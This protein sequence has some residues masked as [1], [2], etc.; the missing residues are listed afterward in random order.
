MN[1]PLK[2]KAIQGAKWTTVESVV[3]TVIQF[4]QVAVLAHILGPKAF[5]L[6]AM[7]TVVVGFG[8]AFSDMGIGNAIIHRQDITNENLSSLYWLNVFAGSAIFMILFLATPII[9]ILYK[10]PQLKSILYWASA[11]FLIV[12]WGQQYQLLLQKEL[13]FAWLAQVEILSVTT[14]AAFA[15]SFALSGYGALSMIWGQLIS[16]SVRTLLLIRPGRSIWRPSRRFAWEDTRGF[17]KF[18]LYQL[19]ERSTNF[20]ST[21]AD[22]MMIG[23]L[24]G[25][26]S[27]GY[28]NVA[29]NLTIQP[30]ARINPILTRVAFPVFSKIQTQ[31][32][33]LK[34]GYLKLVWLLCMIN[35][36]VF[37]GMMVVAANMVATFFGPGWEPSIPLV[38]ALVFVAMLRSTI[39]PIG[40]LLLARGRAD[41]GFRW[42]IGVVFFQTIG[43]FFGAKLGGVL[44]VV[45]TL[46]CFQFVYNIFNYLFLVRRL[47][48]PCLRAYLKSTLPPAGFSFLMGTSV[49]LISR[50]MEDIS[51]PVTWMLFIQIGFGVSLYTTFTYFWQPAFWIEI[52]G[53]FRSRSNKLG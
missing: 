53:V 48:G 37:F 18:G 9:S 43:I 12:P 27:L 51:M 34:R 20:I 45:W 15:I 8:H 3:V 5:G 1:A 39:N 36:P 38:Q 25:M 29:W 31:V 40:S 21:H 11:M 44:G 4:S 47:L 28:Y 50:W 35:F 49:W 19:G 7:S 16:A 17:L 14:G 41:W 22:R 32:D 10:E 26:E 30:L 2:A 46:V 13:K 6:I 52:Q 23:G 42:N 24:L 33:Q